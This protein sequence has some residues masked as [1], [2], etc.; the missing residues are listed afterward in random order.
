[1]RRAIALACDSVAAGGGP[2]GAVIARGEEVVAEGSNLVTPDLDP[3]AHAEVT[4]IRRAC[5]TLGRF[6]LRGLV[7]YSSCE[8]CPMCL[9]AIHWARLDGAY[10]AGTR[11]DA[12]AAGFDDELLYR[13][14]AAPLEARTV[15]TRPLLPEDGKRPFAAWLAKPDRVPY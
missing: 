2:F 9:A 5:R 1:M 3:T 7:L 12:A 8:P 13:E 11:W 6:D 15:P 10:F 4:A 14:V